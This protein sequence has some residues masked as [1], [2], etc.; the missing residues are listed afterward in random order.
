MKP[1][2]KTL[3]RLLTVTFMTLMLVG[4]AIGPQ[5]HPASESASGAGFNTADDAPGATPTEPTLGA[6][7]Q[8]EDGGSADPDA[9]PPDVDTLDDVEQGDTEDDDGWHDDGWHDDT[10]SDDVGPESEGEEEGA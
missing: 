7:E 1:P 10:T 3:F 8:T 5:P 9:V 2:I 4:C 6:D